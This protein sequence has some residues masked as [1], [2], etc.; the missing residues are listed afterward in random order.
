ME[1]TLADTSKTIGFKATGNCCIK[2]A[3][4]IKGSSKMGNSMVWESSLE[5]RME[6]RSWNTRES[7]QEENSR[8]K[9]NLPSRNQ[10]TSM[11]VT[12]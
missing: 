1:I 11:M 6:G 10:V 12:S 3:L 2:M 8:V 7:S 9:G 5:R 4:A